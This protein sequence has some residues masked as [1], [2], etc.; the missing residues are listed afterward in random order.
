MEGSFKSDEMEVGGEM[1]PK[2]VQHALTLEIIQ[3]A[4]TARR[5]HD[6]YSINKGKD[7]FES[8]Y[9]AALGSIGAV[10]EQ[11]PIIE[12]S[13]HA[14]E[15]TGDP[16]QAQKLKEDARRRFEPQILRET[17]IIKPKPKKADE[18]PGER[19]YIQKQYGK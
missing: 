12:T 19:Q 8:T 14:I 2:P 15:A 11:I 16:Y 3:L 13:V 1:L 9:N 5:I 4:A 7:E 10:A 6:N 18:K 17:G